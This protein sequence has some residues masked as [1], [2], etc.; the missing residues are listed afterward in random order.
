MIGNCTLCMAPYSLEMSVSSSQERRLI[1]NWIVLPICVLF[2]LLAVLAYSFT[3][4]D[5]DS[6]SL[7]RRELWKKQEIAWSDVTRVGRLGFGADVV[8]ISYGRSVE[9]Y[10]WMLASP[11][12]RSGFIDALRRYAPHAEF[13][14]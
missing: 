11:R 4:L 3:Y 7:R 13:D 14:L 1:G 8:K 9:N 6:T 10:G 5:L 12:N 2:F